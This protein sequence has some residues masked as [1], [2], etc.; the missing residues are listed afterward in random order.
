MGKKKSASDEEFL[1]LTQLLFTYSYGMTPQVYSL[2]EQPS[3]LP[4]PWGFK[5]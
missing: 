5:C 3:P 2:R 1:E 4:S